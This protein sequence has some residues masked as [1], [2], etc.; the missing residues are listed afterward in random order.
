ME[1]DDSNVPP[2]L[3]ASY[4]AYQL[5]QNWDQMSP[6]QKANGAASIGVQQFKTPE[7]TPLGELP[8]AQSDT[9]PGLNLG[10]TLDLFS[11][12]HNAYPV[13]KNWDQMHTIQ[14]V[15]GGAQT[16]ESIANTAQSM[17]LVGHGTQGAAVKN[18]NTKTL[19]DAGFSAAPN[20]GIGALTGPV[21]SQIP[22]G[23]RTIARAG[24]GV[25]VAP[26]GNADV[27][28]ESVPP[29]SSS[30]SALSNAAGIAAPFAVGAFKIY[31]AWGA[32]GLKDVFNGASG[33]SALAA[34]LVGGQNAPFVL[35]GVMAA[36]TFKNALKRGKSGDQSGRDGALGFMKSNGYVPDTNMLTLPDG[37]QVDLGVDGRGN[38]HTVKDPGMLTDEHGDRKGSNKLNYW[39][40]DYTNDL[41]FFTGSAGIT[42]STMLGGGRSK[43]LEQLGGKIGN[44][45]LANIGYGQ[46]FT[47]ENFS[48]AQQNMRAIYSQM[49]VKSKSDAYQ[50][51][52]QM[53]A[54][55]RISDSDHAAFAQNISMVFDSSGYKTAQKLYSGRM[56]GVQVAS[57]QQDKDPHNTTDVTGKQ[58]VIPRFNV[59]PIEPNGPGPLPAGKNTFNNPPEGTILLTNKLGEGPKFSMLS[60][61]NTRAAMGMSKEEVQ[62]QNQLLY[63]EEGASG[64]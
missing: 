54:E 55:H 44:G 64:L 25:V 51:I 33:G 50:L 28:K 48:K 4:S 11:K 3:T 61:R 47:P 12:G 36:S 27:A 49:G 31:Q 43:A 13:A 32:G 10:Q 53:Y 1:T 37:T 39:D 45:G 6:A 20:Y 42:L 40:T 7:G 57:S 59:K 38:Q 16:P 14:Q 23:Y 17:N 34:G 62:S 18:V 46:D 19:K 26:E 56:R 63:S 30:L 9:A 24:E 22:P 29:G 58:P 8:V 15:V 2:S 5:F 60:D 35:G 21:G 52:N 41:D